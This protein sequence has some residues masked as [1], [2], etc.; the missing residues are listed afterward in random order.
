MASDGGV[1]SF[2]APFLGSMGGKH[3]AAPV[4]GI[5]ATPD[6]DGYWLVAIDGGVFSFGDAPFEGS[7]VDTLSPRPLIGITAA[8]NGEGYW[9]AAVDASVDNEGWAAD[10]GSMAGHALAAGIVGVAST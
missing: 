8:S 7:P 3:L 2:D 9:L 6:A 4:R 1:F 10:L 5:A